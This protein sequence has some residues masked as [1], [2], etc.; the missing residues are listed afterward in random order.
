[1][2]RV[3]PSRVPTASRLA[4]IERNF[5]SG[6]FARGLQLAET[7]SVVVLTSAGKDGLTYGK[8]RGSQGTIYAVVL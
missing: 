7:D 5:D 3:R 4:V 8:V 2:F 6:S 1:M